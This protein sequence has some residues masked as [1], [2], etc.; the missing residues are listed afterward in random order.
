[1]LLSCPPT[2][3]CN[4]MTV[5]LYALDTFIVC[6]RQGIFHFKMVACALIQKGEIKTLQH[7][8]YEHLM[9]WIGKHGLGPTGWK[10]MWSRLIWFLVFQWWLFNRWTHFSFSKHFFDYH[11]EVNFATGK[12]CLYAG[13]VS[14]QMLY[15]VLSSEKKTVAIWQVWPAIW[16]DLKHSGSEDVMQWEMHLV[17]ATQK[18]KIRNLKLF[19]SKHLDY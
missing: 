10:D 18:N 6:N 16:K 11:H 13:H 4:L 2:Y 15:F 1:M 17:A 14:R 3:G 7:S 8:Y 9:A 5:H 12:W 19:C